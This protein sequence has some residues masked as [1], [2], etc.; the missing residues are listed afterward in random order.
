[1]GQA[2]FEGTMPR[3]ARAIDRVAELLGGRAEY[4]VINVGADEEE[5][6]ARLNELG[7]Q[8]FVFREMLDADAGEMV[9]LMERRGGER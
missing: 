9:I 5:L 7:E 1:M 3:L 4:R 8:G 6:E 2:F